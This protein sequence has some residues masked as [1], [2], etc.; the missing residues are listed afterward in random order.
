MYV[1]LKFCGFYYSF[2]IT[3]LFV[4]HIYVSFS[5]FFSV[6]SPCLSTSS[7]LSSSVWFLCA[8]LPFSLPA[9][10]WLYFSFLAYNTATKNVWVTLRNT[11]H[12]PFPCSSFIPYSS[13]PH[14][15]RLPALSPI[16]QA[17]WTAGHSGMLPTCRSSLPSAD[18]NPLSNATECLAW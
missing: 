6:S 17:W 3:V 16:C 4:L 11:G 8:R 2:Y 12:A 15:P 9:W 10:M 14:L 5:L 18:C 1:R 7:S 13:L